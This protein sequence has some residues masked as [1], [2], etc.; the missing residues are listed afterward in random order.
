MP[1][2]NLRAKEKILQSPG[3]E[4]ELRAAQTSHPDWKQL[5][6]APWLHAGFP[7]KQE[8]GLK[9]FQISTF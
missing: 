9:T 3:D 5:D 4:Q 6:L 8:G 1:C 7:G 2:E